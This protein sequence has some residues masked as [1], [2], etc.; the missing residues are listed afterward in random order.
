MYFLSAGIY[1]IGNL[2]F[3]IFGKATVQ[4]WNDTTTKITKE[5]IN[6]DKKHSIDYEISTISKN[7][8]IIPEKIIEKDDT[9]I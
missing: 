1:I 6:N 4:S 8:N 7:Y 9:N 3:I 5:N 2:V